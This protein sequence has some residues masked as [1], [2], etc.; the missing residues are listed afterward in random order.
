T[1]AIKTMRTSRIAE[2]RT[3]LRRDIWIDML[4]RTI[5]AVHEPLIGSAGRQ[6]CI[7]EQFAELAVGKT[8][9]LVQTAV[10]V[11]V[12]L[13]ANE[14]AAVMELVTVGDAVA[15][16]RHINPHATSRLDHPGVLD[17]I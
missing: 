10:P 17:T 2:E 11:G 8:L 5:W 12:L 1:I 9:P 15:P 3:L 14:H 13:G 4:Q 7:N 6:G 16:R